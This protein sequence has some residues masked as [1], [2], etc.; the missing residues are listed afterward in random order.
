MLVSLALCNVDKAHLNRISGYRISRTQKDKNGNRD[1]F[2]I[3]KYDG[4]RLLYHPLY[5]RAGCQLR[6]FYGNSTKKH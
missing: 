5:I 3:I 6:N 1:V 2:N 4:R